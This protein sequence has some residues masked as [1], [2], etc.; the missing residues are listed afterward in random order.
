M[1][2][3][4]G[5]INISDMSSSLSRVLRSHTVHSSPSKK[6]KVPLL[7]ALLRFL[8][9]CFHLGGGVVVDELEQTAELEDLGLVNIKRSAV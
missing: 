8:L 7:P 6:L 1:F 4:R 9:Y 3:N 5:E 2:H